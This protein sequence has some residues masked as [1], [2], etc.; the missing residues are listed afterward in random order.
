MRC[1]VAEKKDGVL[2]E[3][4]AADNPDQ[5][6]YS[7]GFTIAELEHFLDNSVALATFRLH[8]GCAAG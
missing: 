5:T 7:D 1:C 3:A 2:V 4:A 6:E 8:L